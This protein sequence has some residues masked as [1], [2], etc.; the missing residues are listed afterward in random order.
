MR[1]L[2]DF[3]LIRQQPKLPEQQTVI[4]PPWLLVVTIQGTDC[5]HIL[6]SF[7]KKGPFDSTKFFKWKKVNISTKETFRN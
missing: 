6:F 4:Q 1:K 3:F 7:G 2:R 5:P